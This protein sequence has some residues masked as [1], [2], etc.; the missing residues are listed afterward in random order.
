[1]PPQTLRQKNHTV[2]VCWWAMQENS[3]TFNL[4]HTGHRRVARHPAH[5]RRRAIDLFRS[6]AGGVGL[7][8]PPPPPDPPH[9]R[10]GGEG[11][12][13]G[14]PLTPQT[15]STPGLR[16]PLSPF[17]RFPPRILFSRIQRFPRCHW[18]TF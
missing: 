5:S 15:P 7:W 16:P 13:C 9:P 3:Q 2:A 17:S 10:L 18:S 12:A 6:G 14:R 4:N 8:P 1:M 11:A